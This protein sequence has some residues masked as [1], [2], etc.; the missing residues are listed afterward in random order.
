MMDDIKPYCH[1]GVNIIELPVQWILDD[2]VHFGF[3]S[4]DWTKKISTNSEV[5][6]IWEA[7]FEGIYKLGGSFILTM[8]PQVI[9]RPSRLNMLDNFISYLKSYEG[10]WITTCEKI[11]RQV[12]MS[13]D[14]KR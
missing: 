1:T 10:V 9:G 12:S 3:G 13:Y 8:H 11:A 5:S 6:E 4:G 7:E 2:W 14:M